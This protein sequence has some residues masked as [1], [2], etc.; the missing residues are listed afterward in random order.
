MPYDIFSEHVDPAR[1]LPRDR[2]IK[3]ETG[4]I[5]HIIQKDPYGFWHIHMDKGPVPEVLSGA[6]T[7][8]GKAEKAVNKYISDT[9]K[10]KAELG[11]SQPQ[12]LPQP[13][14]KAEAKE[15]KKKN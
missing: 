7:T 6:Y 11:M 3:L 8:Y 4:N 13:E 1:D 15:L 12:P 5:Y 14:A 9:G 2:Q 10:I